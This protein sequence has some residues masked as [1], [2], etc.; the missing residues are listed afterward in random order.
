RSF[1]VLAYADERRIRHGGPRSLRL[2]DRAGVFLHP[3][4]SPAPVVIR[5]W[6]FALS[7]PSFPVIPPPLEA[8]AVRSGGRQAWRPALG[9]PRP[10]RWATASSPCVCSRSWPAAP[11]CC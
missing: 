3:T 11:P 6:Q 10:W 8:D 5:P 4:D 2:G 7:R 1:E 9:G